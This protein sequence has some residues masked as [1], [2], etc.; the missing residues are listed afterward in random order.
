[1]GVGLEMLIQGRLRVE[2]LM[3]E[4]AL[5][6]VSVEG[7]IAD[8]VSDAFLLVPFDL[9]VGDASVGVSFADDLQDAFTVKVRRLGTGRA[10]E[11]VR[12]AA[13]CDVIAVGTEDG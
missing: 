3:A 12:Q 11:V 7:P 6:A 13:R 9:L 2:L 4:I 10:L 5:P 1:M 8:F